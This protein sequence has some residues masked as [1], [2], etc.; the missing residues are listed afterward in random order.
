MARVT[1]V[2]KEVLGSAINVGKHVQPKSDDKHNDM[3]PFH[4]HGLTFKFSRRQQMAKPADGC[5][6]Q[7]RI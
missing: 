4:S 5:R 1:R 6:V 3:F 7:R 2:E